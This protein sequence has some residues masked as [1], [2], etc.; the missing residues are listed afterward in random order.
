MTSLRADT[1]LTL[2]A[3]VAHATA[4]RVA[5]TRHGDAVELALGH[6]LVLEQELLDLAQRR[7][8]RLTPECVPLS[9]LGGMLVSGGSGV[10]CSS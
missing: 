10:G 8:L 7:G 5:A 2:L 1:L 4:V 3:L 6:D 9:S